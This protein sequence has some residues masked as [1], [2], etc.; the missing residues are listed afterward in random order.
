MS[1]TTRKKRAIV[2]FNLGGPDSPAAVEPFLFNL[3]NDPAIISLPN[4]FRFLLAKLI[5]RRRAPIAREIYDHIGGK[6]PLLELTQEQADA[7]QTALNGEDDGYENR[8]FIAMRYWKPFADDTAAAVKAWGADEQIL[9]PLYPQFSTT[10]SG[11]SVKD[12]KRACAKVGLTS[13]IK[14]A[15]CY[16]T[17]LL[18]PPPR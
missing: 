14:T 16:P 3:F 9:L 1:E 13:P 5:S 17:N 8:C 2:L 7:L 12:W 10:T 6:S 18:R 15:C 11:S 4:P